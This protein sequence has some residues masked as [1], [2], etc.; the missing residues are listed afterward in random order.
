MNKKIAALVIPNIIS[1]I[2]V[3]LLGV[4]DTAIA[5]RL[6]NGEQAIGAIS[7][8]ATIFNL[9]YWNCAFLRMGSSGVTAQA[10]GARKLEECGNI[11]VRAVIIALILSATLLLLQNP[12]SKLSFAIMFGSDTVESIAI[13]Y[14]DIR[15]WAAPATVSLYA[16]QGW[17]IG[18]QNSK[19]P[20]IC[21]FILNIINIVAGVVLVF[22]FG[23]GIEGV[24]YATVAAQYSGLLFMLLVLAAKYSRILKRGVR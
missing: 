21:S 17:F 22:Q 6:S 8:G 2:T 7:I 12:I 11:L 9:I 14:F 5:G 23:M 4:V 10:L 19:T 3:P 1:N 20:M 18:M 24:A 15:I 16:I 13:R